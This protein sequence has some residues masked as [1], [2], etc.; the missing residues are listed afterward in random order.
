M[1]WL[2]ILL[3]IAFAALLGL[4]VKRRLAGALVG[5][6]GVLLFRPL[7]VVFNGNLYL[8]LGL[9][10]VAGLLLGLI[11]RAVVLRQRGAD[12]LFSV[13]GGLGGGLLGILL[14]LVFV[15]SLPLER[16]VNDQIVYPAQSLPGAVRS[17]V[18]ASPLVNLGRDILLYPLLEAGGQ[19]TANSGLYRALHSFLV[20]GNPWEGG[21]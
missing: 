1:T 9:A 2:D 12:I 17:A 21:S 20:V 18:N 4:G 15:T 11:S 10:L 3:M 5:L 19:V 13:L 14:L 7:L 6:G 16:N 8:A